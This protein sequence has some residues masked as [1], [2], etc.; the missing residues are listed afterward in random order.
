MLANIIF[1]TWNK[2]KIES[3]NRVLQDEI[4]IFDALKILLQKEGCNFIFK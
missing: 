3:R 2:V 1:K 4:S